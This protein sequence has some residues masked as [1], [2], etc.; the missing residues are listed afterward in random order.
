MGRFRDVMPTPEEARFLAAFLGLVAVAEAA[1][2][3][4]RLLHG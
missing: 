1:W 2:L 3:A 4:A